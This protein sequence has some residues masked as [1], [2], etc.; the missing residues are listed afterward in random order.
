[1]TD[2]FRRQAS[3]GKGDGLSVA[4]VYRRHCDRDRGSR[5][6]AGGADVAG[7]SGHREISRSSADF[8]YEGV[9]EA[10]ADETA[11]CEC[12]GDGEITA[13][14]GPGHVRVAIGIDR[15]CSYGAKSSIPRDAVLV[16]RAAEEARID[17][18]AGVTQLQDECVRGTA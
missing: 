11:A 7:R 14:G 18:E 4:G 2:S 8:G 17:G 6:A 10:A 9:G 5:G 13:I 15:N 12:R 16:G 3:T 1:M